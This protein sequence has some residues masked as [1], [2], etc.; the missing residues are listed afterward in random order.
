MKDP[1][2]PEETGTRRAVGV[3]PAALDPTLLP[4]A[5]PPP[6]P[7]AARDSWWR[8]LTTMLLAL[9]TFEELEAVREA[10][11]P[12]EPARAT[13]PPLRAERAFGTT[14]EAGPPRTPPPAADACSCF[15]AAS[16]CLC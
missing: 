1:I 6:P 8:S 15:W 11:F 5:L 12:P 13:G 7:A 14:T 2:T 10:L 4:L 3:P 9:E 16:I